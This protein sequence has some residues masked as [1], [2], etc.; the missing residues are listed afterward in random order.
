M[1]AEDPQATRPLVPL[2]D[3]PVPSRPATQAVLTAVPACPLPV[4]SATVAPAASFIRQKAR[5]P[6]YTELAGDEAGSKGSEPAACSM[7]VV[8]P[9]PS[10]STNGSGLATTVTGTGAEST[11]PAAVT[12]RA[13]RA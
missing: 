6:E 12:A 5:N 13:V 2:K 10:P 9:S 11:G 3:R 8:N 7:A 1:A 4:A